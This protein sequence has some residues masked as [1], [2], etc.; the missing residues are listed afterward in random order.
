MKHFSPVRPPR[1]TLAEVC[2]F[3]P[4]LEKGRAHYPSS[5]LNEVPTLQ[6]LGFPSFH[7]GQLPSSQPVL[8]ILTAS[9]GVAPHAPC[10]WGDS[11]THSGKIRGLFPATS[12]LHISSFDKSYFNNKNIF[13]LIIQFHNIFLAQSVQKIPKYKHMPL[14][15]M[16]QISVTS[17]VPLYFDSSYFA[18]SVSGCHGLIGVSPTDFRRGDPNPQYISEWGL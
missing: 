16:D 12:I 13:F 6:S 17:G 2:I 14:H 5:F 15:L 7:A 4:K 11:L 10:S 1:P 3:S 9:L 8:L 18:F